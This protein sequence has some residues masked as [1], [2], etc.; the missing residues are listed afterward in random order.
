[1]LGYKRDDV[2]TDRVNNVPIIQTSGNVMPPIGVGESTPSPNVHP[3][4]ENNSGTSRG[5]YVRNQ[6]IDLQEISG[7]PLEERL[8]SS[9]DRRVISGNI[10]IG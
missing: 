7:I 8:T 6:D 3:E 1:M 4:S 10:N 9:K 5:S 2:G